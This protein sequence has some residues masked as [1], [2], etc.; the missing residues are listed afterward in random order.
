[1]IVLFTDFGLTDP[2]IGQL[3]AVLA[4]EAP[5]VPVIDLFHAVPDFN[6][7]AGAYL[8]PA[9]AREFPPGTVFVCVVDPGV[10][11]GRRAVMLKA[12]K[13]WYVGPDNGLFEMVQRRAT[14]Y[15]CRAIRWRPPGMSASFHGRDLFAPVAARL[16]RGDMPDAE[17]AGLTLPPDAPWPDDLA[18][19]LHIDHYGNGISGLR[20]ESVPV[21]RA[22]R[23]GREVL[24]YAQ[25]FSDVPPGTAFW[26]QNSNG[27]VE[28]AVNGG[29]A[30]V[31][32]GFKPG[33]P[34]TLTQP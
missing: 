17:P 27:L 19:I 2:Y 22:I 5:G 32:L 28:I 6:I 18:E 31:R 1:M 23:I 34:L 26:Y 11:S 20:A 4:R 8:L 24:K 9:Y 3:H 33:D 25:V 16:A 15:E 29:S 30:A 14:E 7:R 13:C 10:G 21:S 12:D